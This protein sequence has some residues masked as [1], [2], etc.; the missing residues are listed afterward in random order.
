VRVLDRIEQVR[1]ELAGSG[2]RVVVGLVPTMGALHEGHLSL[3]RRSAAE[4]DVTLV[5]VFVNPLQFGPRE[6]LARYP[7]DL[8]GDVAAA[9][10]AGAG[11]LFAPP[12]E[13]MYPSPPL[14]RVQVQGGLAHRWEGASRPGHFSGVATVVTK[15]F[16]ITGPC[17]AYF[18]EK[19]YQQLLVVH[20]LVADLSLPVDV[21]GCPTVRETDG[22]ALSSRNRY[23]S[24]DERSAAAVLYRALH[25]AASTPERD[26]ATLQSLMTATVEAEPLARLDYAAVVDP[27]TL[28]TLHGEVADARLLVAAWVGGTRL[29]DNMARS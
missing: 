26:A 10:R 6:D 27:A 8:D 17:R 13:E 22:L 29:I 19:D 23:L 28:D 2:P 5:T 11:L 1:K 9:A 4:C 12:V 20:R 18:G 21:V 24:Q 15:L 7:R 3:I 16:S 14:V 25:A